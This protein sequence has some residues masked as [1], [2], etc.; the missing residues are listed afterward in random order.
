MK[1][2]K[3]DL[4]KVKDVYEKYKNKGGNSDYNFWK[5]A[6]GRNKISI[7]PP[8]ND[9]GMYFHPVQWHYGIGD[10]NLSLVCPSI[11]KKKC[12]ICEKSKSLYKLKGKED[13]KLATALRS[14]IRFSY[15]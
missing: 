3:V 4:K 15:N 6:V 2:R 5:P 8:W 1:V 11:I 7:L 14:K 12:P 9:G 10:E 13:K